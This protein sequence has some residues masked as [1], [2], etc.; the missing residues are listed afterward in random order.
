M[1]QLGYPRYVG[2]SLVFDTYYADPQC[3]HSVGSEPRERREGFVH[4]RWLER[5]GVGNQA[6]LERGAAAMTLT[7]CRIVCL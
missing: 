6:V 3:R 5:F 7:L 2:S 4:T 1:K